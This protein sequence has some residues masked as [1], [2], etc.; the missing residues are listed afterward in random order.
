MTDRELVTA[1]LDGVAEL[2]TDE[3]R[4]VEALLEAE[5]AARDEAAATRRLLGELRALPG[6][7][8][9]PD[10]TQLDRQ[11]REA[12]GPA[13]PAARRGWLRWLVPAGVLASAAVI[14]IVLLHDP[15]PRAP[16]PRRPARSAAPVALRTLDAARPAPVQA[17]DAPDDEAEVWLD[18]EAVGVGDVDP[19]VLYDEDEGASD[20]LA[21]DR[22]LLLPADDL[23]WIDALDDR[24]L[25]RAEQWLDR[26]HGAEPAGAKGHGKG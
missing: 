17:A 3:R 18:G 15:R 4:R 12:V 7:G 24:A 6:E 1:Y 13:V 21:D 26:E 10:W 16:D 20:E 8:R 23:R 2:P 5:P 14:V 19:G 22:Q 25:D 9:E 11:I